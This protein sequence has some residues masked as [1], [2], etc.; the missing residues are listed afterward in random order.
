MMSCSTYTIVIFCRQIRST[1]RDRSCDRDLRVSQNLPLSRDIVVDLQVYLRERRMQFG[2]GVRKRVKIFLQ[3]NARLS[4]FFV[5][6]L[7]SV[8]TELRYL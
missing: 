8:R 4:D 5:A 3:T 6:R 1:S 2:A 7:N